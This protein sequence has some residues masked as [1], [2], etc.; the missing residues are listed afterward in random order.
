[1]K[2]SDLLPKKWNKNSPEVEGLAILERLMNDSIPV[3][4]GLV[5]ADAT[6]TGITAWIEGY[7][8][9]VTRRTLYMSSE[10]SA[11]IMVELAAAKFTI[12]DSRE[13]PV[14]LR[15]SLQLDYQPCL[16]IWMPGG[17]R[18][19]LFECCSARID[20]RFAP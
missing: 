2:M 15:Q 6:G 4:C 18:C 8:R 20:S 5:C 16:E 12:P 9:T 17:D 19:L 14:D 7:I 1:M 13:V 10:H 3:L 11:R